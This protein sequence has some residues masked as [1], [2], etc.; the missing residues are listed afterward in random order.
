MELYEIT[1]NW[2]FSCCTIRSTA[3]WLWMLLI[4]S[5]GVWGAFWGGQSFRYYPPK[6]QVDISVHQQSVFIFSVSVLWS[7]LRCRKAGFYYGPSAFS[8]INQG[9]YLQYFQ[10]QFDIWSILSF[11][12][13]PFWL[14]FPFLLLLDTN[15]ESWATKPRHS[16]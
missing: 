6:R 11:P 12:S 7:L 8:Y 1:H 14:H 10:V 5:S 16:I 3:C 9:K 4:S 13:F 15:L 2:P